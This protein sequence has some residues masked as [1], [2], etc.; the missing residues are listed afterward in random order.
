[1]H[2]ATQVSDEGEA[3]KFRVGDRVCTNDAY[4]KAGGPRAVRKP[5]SGVVKRV[6]DRPQRLAVV[7]DGTKSSQN[8]R[9]CWF[10]IEVPKVIE[11]VVAKCPQL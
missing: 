7:K 5:W 2:E 11:E 8:Y 9:A 6:L 1:M 10:E 3:M 4:I